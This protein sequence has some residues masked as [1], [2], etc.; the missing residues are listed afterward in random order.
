MLHLWLTSNRSALNYSNQ[1]LYNRPSNI[2]SI[3]GNRDE[4][5]FVHMMVFMNLLLALFKRDLP[6][7][8]LSY[9][10]GMFRFGRIENLQMATAKLVT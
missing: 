3:G 6:V 2:F 7:V 1:C 10:K 9:L 4:I 5:I 8:F